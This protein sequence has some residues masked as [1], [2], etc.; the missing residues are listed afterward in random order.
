MRRAFSGWLPPLVG[1]LILCS[2]AGAFAAEQAGKPST[3]LFVTE[4]LIL[5]VA[6]RLLGEAMQRLGQPSVMGHLLAGVVL[7]PSVFGALWPEAQQALFPSEAA[8]K[9]MIDAVGQVGVL[10]LLLLAGM[11]TDIGLARRTG[12]ASLAVSICGILLPFACG[13]A[14]G[15]YLPDFLLPNP[16]ERFPAALLLGTALSISSVKIV[17]VVVRE[18]NFMR[19]NIGQVILASA[20]IDDT[21]GWI[22]IAITLSLVENN[23]LD[24][25]TLAKS[26]LGTAVFLVVSFTVGRRVVFWLI[27]WANDHFES[28]LPVISLVLALTFS[29]AL[30][31]DAIGVH[32]VLG[33]FVAGILVGQSPILT[34]Q[35]DQQLRGVITA[36]FMPIFFGL[37][38][39]TADLTI[40]ANPEILMLTAGIV[41]IATVGKFS[42]A[43]AG[44]R[45]GGL[46]LPESLA[47]ACGMNARGSTE[48][49]V[50]TIGLS[51]GVLSQDLFTMIVT[52]AVLTTLAM[53]PSLRWALA[54]LPMRE[55]ERQRIEREEFEAKGFMPNVERLLLAVDDSPNGKFMAHLTGLLAGRRGTPTTLLR[56]RAPDERP[57][58]RPKEEDHGPEADLKAGAETAR[59]A[60]DAE[61]A[62]SEA[63]AQEEMTGKA[64]PSQEEAAPEEK[65]APKTAT[66]PVPLIK[67]EATAAQAE[68]MVARESRKGYDLMMVGVDETLGPDGALHED[69]ARIVAGF[70][71]PLGVTIARGGHREDP[72]QRLKILVPVSGNNVSRR[73][74]EVAVMLARAQG[75]PITF[76][77]VAS[78]KRD[79]RRRGGALHQH[80]Q[81]ALK[82]LVT[83]AERYDTEADI[84]VHTELAPHE[85]ILREIK[86]RGF[87]LVVMGV[88]RRPGE[89]LF[90]GNVAG[91]VIADAEASVLLL[92][93]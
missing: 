51:M 1:A 45:L 60:H 36:L 28:E 42:G 86:R 11:E 54:R 14:L 17:A 74:A 10:M 44:G 92:S 68:A 27:R 31:T 80:E 61:Q 12:R 81:A 87:D 52:M 78:G 19:R 89:A 59:G 32:D 62:A 63:A 67:A 70:E 46:R 37:A 22:V 38:G 29:M 40:L 84:S 85:A 48:V 50:A 64:E 9:G 26:V 53:P 7:G 79:G 82:E 13:F 3:P 21:I 24:W 23:H 57:K 55:E 90:F 76:L 65:K 15:I 2:A 91:A 47:I 77:Y 72:T 56:V 73:A 43:F 88:N 71:G 25:P 58:S 41:A 83:W 5:V 66:P 35:I 93:S 6:G 16:E 39:I 20:V 4:V 33:A 8:Q 34:R 75:V 69:I 30:I 49:I 18:M